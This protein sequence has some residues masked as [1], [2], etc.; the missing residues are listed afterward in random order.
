MQYTIAILLVIVSFQALR[1]LRNAAFWF[2]ACGWL[3]NLLYLAATRSPELLASL[4][5]SPAVDPTTMANC[6]DFLGNASFW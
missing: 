1:V 6:F 2:V 3:A 4:A 5:R